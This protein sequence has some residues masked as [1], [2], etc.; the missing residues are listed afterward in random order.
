MNACSMQIPYDFPLYRPPS[1]G[2]SLIFQVTLGGP[3]TSAR[4]VICIERKI[5]GKAMVRC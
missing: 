5:C 1:E 4:S 3:L 2:N